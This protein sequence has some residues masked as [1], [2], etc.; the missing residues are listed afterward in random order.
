MAGHE[1]HPVFYESEQFLR[2]PE[3]FEEILHSLVWG[4]FK[5]YTHK[6]KEINTYK[7][8]QSLSNTL[9]LLDPGGDKDSER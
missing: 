4:Q 9:S 7:D 1:K 5:K 8:G 3:A 6:K 2:F